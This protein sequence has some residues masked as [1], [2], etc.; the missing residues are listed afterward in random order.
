MATLTGTG[1]MPD[2]SSQTIG[3]TVTA[4]LEKLAATATA[5]STPKPSGSTATA[6]STSEPSGNVATAGVPRMTQN[7]VL[8]GAA[9]V[10]GGAMML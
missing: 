5:A 7:A 2:I 8:A 6:A 1:T 3:V 10:F 9:V 4:G